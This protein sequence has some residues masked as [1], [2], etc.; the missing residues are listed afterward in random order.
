MTVA[1]SSKKTALVTGVSGFIAQHITDQLLKQGYRVRGTARSTTKYAALTDHFTSIYGKERF[2]IVE[3]KDLEDHGAFDEAV[4]A[5]DLIFHVASPLPKE[6]LDPYQG[7]INPAVNGTLSLLNAAHLYGSASRV[8]LTSSFAAM[9]DEPRPADYVY[10]EK[11]WNESSLRSVKEQQKGQGIPKAYSASKSEAEKAAWKFMKEK[12][13]RFDLACINPVFVFG[14]PLLRIEREDDIRFSIRILYSHINGELTSVNQQPN[15]FVDVRDVARA[16]VV[17]AT[18]PRAA[19][20]RFLLSAG[21]FSSARIAEIIRKRFP[22]LTK[23]PTGDPADKLFCNA[24]GSKATE[25]LDIDYIGLEES[26]TD[27]IDAL[28]HMVMDQM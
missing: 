27:T 26:V 6:G 16:H 23:V 10:S 11:D 15:N 24:D 13:P 21:A 17:A 1:G 25:I 4:K 18:E 8:V 2:E 5:Q 14:P 9:R 7:F 19:G 22:N 20:Q 3:V 28:K 12:Q